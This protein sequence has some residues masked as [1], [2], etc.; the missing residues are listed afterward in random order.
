M[1]PDVLRAENRR[2][3][4]LL[5]LIRI[6]NCKGLHAAA[7][8]D[9]EIFKL[10]SPPVSLLDPDYLLQKAIATASI[11]MQSKA[12]A[13]YVDA[14]VLSPVTVGAWHHQTLHTLY[15]FGRAL[16]AWCKH[17]QAVKLLASCCQGYH[18]TFG[19]SHPLSKRALK[20]L[21]A[22]EGAEVVMQKLRHLGHINKA[23][24]GS[25]QRRTSRVI[26]RHQS[27]C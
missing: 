2:L 8:K 17:E 23:A 25:G 1:T 24:R 9:L 21:E 10:A 16:K 26:S 3:P 12:Q 27:N 19:R 20:E 18:Y 22:C 13:S 6:W 4:V 15:E 5:T 11:G 14:V 7:Y